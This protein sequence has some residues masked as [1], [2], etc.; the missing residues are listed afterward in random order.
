MS[1]TP[2]LYIGAESGPDGDKAYIYSINNRKEIQIDSTDKNFSFFGATFE[3]KEIEFHGEW[4]AEYLNQLD[5]YL[6][7]SKI[8]CKNHGHKHSIPILMIFQYNNEWGLFRFGKG[9]FRSVYL[10]RLSKINLLNL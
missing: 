7:H 4:P 1:N 3:E 8:E 9:H 6:F 10:P 2:Y 5:K